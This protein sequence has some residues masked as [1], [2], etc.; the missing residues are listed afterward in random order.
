MVEVEGRRA[1]LVVADDALSTEEGYRPFPKFPPA[2]CDR[3]SVSHA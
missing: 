2:P 1:P 3:E